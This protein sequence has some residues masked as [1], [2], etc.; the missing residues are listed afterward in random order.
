MVITDKGCAHHRKEAF[1]HCGRALIRARLLGPVGANRAYEL[2][3][4]SQFENGASGGLGLLGGGAGGAAGQQRRER[5]RGYAHPHQ[6]RLTA[7]GCARWR[8]RVCRVTRL[9]RFHNRF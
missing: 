7:P 3:V 9:L 4:A 8:R 6:G 1:L 5:C 2:S